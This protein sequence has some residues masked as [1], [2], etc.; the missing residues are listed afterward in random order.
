MMKLTRGPS[1]ALARQS[2]PLPPPPRPL[3]RLSPLLL[4][5]VPPALLP[6]PG[7]GLAL[8]ARH[9]KWICSALSEPL[10]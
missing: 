4:Q 2:P 8:R 7:E 6:T 10:I 5:S 9:G 3:P 1:R